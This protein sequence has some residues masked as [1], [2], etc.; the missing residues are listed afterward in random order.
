[1]AEA[2]M[3]ITSTDRLYIQKY[4]TDV[5]D[6]TAADDRFEVSTPSNQKLVIDEDG[7]DTALWNAAGVTFYTADSGEFF[8]LSPSDIANGFPDTNHSSVY[9]SVNSTTKIAG[10][11]VTFGEGAYGFEY[12]NDDF[13]VQLYIPTIMDALEGAATDVINCQCNCE[14]NSAKAQR[15]IKMRAYLDLILYKA[16]TA[17][18]FSN[19][20]EINTMVTTLTN[21]IG[22]TDELCGTC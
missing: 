16:Q 21:F 17:V 3:Y 8:D 1:M 11:A 4:F 10:S 14:I 7:A 20:P 18:G 19:M 13:R 2:R 5:A 12:N 15:Y 6:A 22:G 9:A